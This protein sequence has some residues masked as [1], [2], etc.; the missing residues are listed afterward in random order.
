MLCCWFPGSAALLDVLLVYWM[1]CWFTGWTHTILRAPRG[2]KADCGVCGASI[3]IIAAINPALEL[4]V[5]GKQEK[6]GDRVVQRESKSRGKIFHR[7][8]RCGE[9]IR[10]YPVE[11][12]E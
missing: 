11:R 3:A 8:G 1:C 12:Q 9:L 4:D 2:A 10:G 6:P 5:L 7:D